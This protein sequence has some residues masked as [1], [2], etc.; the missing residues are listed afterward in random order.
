MVATKPSSEVDICNLALDYLNQAPI[1][2]IDNPTTKTAEACARWYHATRRALL[3]EHPWN[4]AIK[5][6]QLPKS[7]ATI[8]FGYS[9]VYELPSDFLRL[10]DPGNDE[11]LDII[12]YNYQIEDNNL[13]TND[14]TGSSTSEL[15]VRYV[16]NVTSVSEFDSSFVIALAA[17]LA[18]KM[19][20]KFT[21][22]E[23][24]L[25]QI[26]ED[27]RKEKADAMSVDGQERP[28][29]RITVS[30]FVEKRRRKRRSGFGTPFLIL[31]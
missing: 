8:P 26:R 22:N 3:R 11:F 5:R 1:T 31:E 18:S 7:T 10:V 27:L 9:N 21:A 6:A 19:A 23:G 15:N 30:K 24:R 13:Y 2:S 28:P 25:E 14:L 4:F 29:R 17:S 12:R 16:R 20:H